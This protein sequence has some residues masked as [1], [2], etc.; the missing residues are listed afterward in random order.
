MRNA[1]YGEE[2]RARR[3]AR[4]VLG[5]GIAVLLVLLSGS[6]ASAFEKW[7]SFQVGFR[8]G[9]PPITFGERHEK[10]EKVEKLLRDS[11]TPE[12][13]E[14]AASKVRG[15]ATGDDR[16]KV[17][18]DLGLAAHTVGT[19]EGGTKTVMIADGYI[20]AISGPRKMQFGYLD[21]RLVIRKWIVHFD[22]RGKVSDTEVFPDGWNDALLKEPKLPDDMG[23]GP[24]ST[25]FDVDYLVAGRRGY[26]FISPQG[27]ERAKP[28]LEKLRPGDSHLALEGASNFR[29]YLLHLRAWPMGDGYIPMASTIEDA[30]GRETLVFGWAEHYE[31]V[32][33][34]RVI[35]ADDAIQEIHF[36]P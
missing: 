2:R 13:W 20:D 5:G 27:W 26:A 28:K 1:G 25:P 23:I 31:P 36:E 4:I 10:S 33:K 30:M 21:H 18:A 16:A 11:L 24:I 17:E 14:R 9:W 22:G 19:E 34:A 7:W 12:A 15:I 6:P 8:L 35:L 32:V 29:Y 3:A